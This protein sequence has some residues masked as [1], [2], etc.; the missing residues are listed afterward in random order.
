MGIR[1]YRVSNANLLAPLL[2]L[3]SS[4]ILLPLCCL[5]RKYI[6]PSLPHPLIPHALCSRMGCLWDYTGGA[7][8]STVFVD[9]GGLCGVFCDGDV[10]ECAL[11]G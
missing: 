3:L 11:E 1:S 2:A 4:N 6:I 7:A 9:A 8:D 10:S 5:L